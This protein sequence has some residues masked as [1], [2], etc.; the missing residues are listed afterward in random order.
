MLL[1]CQNMLADGYRRM[2][3][4]KNK[5]YEYTGKTLFDSNIKIVR[6]EIKKIEDINKLKEL[7]RKE[8]NRYDRIGFH[9]A[10]N[11]RISKIEKYNRV[12]EKGVIDIHILDKLV[13]DVPYCDRDRTKK[14]FSKDVRV[15]VLKRDSS[16]CQLCRDTSTDL[17]C[18]H[19]IPNGPGTSDN[20]IMLCGS[21]HVIVHTLLRKKGYKYYRPKRMA[22]Y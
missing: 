11:E 7:S 2:Y 22:W 14:N 8:K 17:I 1:I 13:N 18:H 6:R 4:V 9:E 20:L 12:I 10:V 3:N 19:I 16:T 21:C 5:K 15:T